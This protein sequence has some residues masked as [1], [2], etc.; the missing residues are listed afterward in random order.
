MPSPRL[1]HVDDGLPGIARERV[2]DGWQYRDPK[3]KIIRD[4]DEIARL[5][6][7]ALPPAYEDAW[8][9]PAANGHILATGYDA[10]GRKQYRYHPDFRLAR[11]ADKYDRCAAFGHALPLLRAR[12][13]SDL[14][15]RNLC[16]E[17]VVG[18]VVRLLD[19]AALRVGNEQYVAA[20]KSFGATTLRQRHARLT[21]Q[22]LRLSY[23]AKG[24]AQ[25]EVAISDRSLTTLVR[26]LQDL[27]GQKLFQ[28]EDYSGVCAVASEDVNAYIREAM[29]DEFS[30]KHFRTWSASVEAFAFLYDA[31]ERP[32]LKVML[33]HVAG[34][35]GNTPAIARKAYVHPAMIAAAQDRS[36][37]AAAAGA[38]PRAAK[39]LSRYERGFLTY[40]ER[41][42]GAAALLRS[43]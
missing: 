7:I 16:Q 25:R 17:R 2:G 41:A 5:N 40:L 27:P 42:P 8:Y 30:A 9:C 13:E 32:T 35:L 22:T 10:R 24:G 18:A 4:R 29:G 3:G 38:L 11:E 23:R 39:Y 43:A 34:H 28:Y 31:P 21:G 33:E 1:I 36:D 26:R 12:L 14:A 6:A 15:R 19:L 20:N 37:F